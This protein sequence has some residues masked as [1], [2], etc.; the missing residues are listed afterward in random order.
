MIYFFVYDKYKIS[1][2]DCLKQQIKN[3][4]L[5]SFDNKFT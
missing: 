1:S 2:L 4:F 5:N 3:F